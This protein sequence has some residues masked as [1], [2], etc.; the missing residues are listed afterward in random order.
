M[1]GIRHIQRVFVL[2]LAGAMVFGNAPPALAY[3]KFGS[4]VNGKQVTLKWSTTPVRYFVNNQGV[5][6]V[7]A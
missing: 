7:T 3:L 6:G 1:I 2:V 5:N 4:E